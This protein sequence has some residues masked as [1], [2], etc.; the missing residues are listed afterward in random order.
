MASKKEKKLAEDQL[1]L[2]RVL[3]LR[4]VVERFVSDYDQQRDSSEVSVRLD[5]LDRINKEFNNIQS[6]IEKLDAAENFER[7]ITIRTDFENRFCSNDEIPTVNK[8]QYLLQS[9]EGD[10]KKPFESVDIQ[11]DNYASTWDAL[12]KRYDDKRFL[13]KELFRGLFDLPLMK[14]ES[15]HELNTLVDDFQRHVKV[16]G[17]LGEPI[18]HWD[19]PLTFI[20]CNK[21][22]VSTLRS[23]EHE[24]RQKEEVKYDELV[25]F[26]IQH[27]R[28]LKSVSSDLQ[29]RSQGATIKVAGTI[30]K[31]LTLQ[32][33]ACSQKHQLYQCPPFANLSVKQRRE[34]ISQR[35]LCWNCFRPN[36]QA[37]ICK[38]KFSCRTCH[39]RHHTLLHDQAAPKITPNPA[40]KSTP[41]NSSNSAPQQQTP[42]TS[43]NVG[44][45]GSSNPPEVNLFV[46][47]RHSTVLLETV[48]L[49]IVDKHG[50]ELRVRAL[51]DSAAM[52]NFITKKLANTLATR[53]ASV[54]IAVA[55]IGESVKQI[56][57]QITATIKSRTS[58][59]STTLEFLIM[60]KP[61][62]NLPTIA[63]NTAMWN[64]PNVPLA[65]PHF[66]IPGMVDIIIGGECYHEIHTGNR[67]SIGDGLP[68]L[69]VT[70][71]PSIDLS[72]QQFNVSGS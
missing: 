38:S 7:H 44:T 40:T 17:K 39:A 24:T 54:D 42:S 5:T 21:L 32:C 10:A 19:T 70:Y 18:K 41:A 30:P 6:E 46:Q 15:A 52:S 49:T 60:K 63:I 45:A 35:S 3:A 1:V 20:L 22:D 23:W 57:R 29:H 50:K 25:E 64:M 56:K 34:L 48:V 66:N 36:H 28:M 62:A 47:S 55:G 59:Y 51:L 2:K 68:L 43:G 11:A 67:L 9:L 4:D 16:L 12:M 58:S 27:V 33:H 13:R 37:K 53:Q 61:T 71:Q 72:K 69:S 31:K 65:D 8:L 14:R 26:L